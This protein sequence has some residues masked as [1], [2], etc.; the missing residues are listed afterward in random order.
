MRRT[1]SRMRWLLVL[2]AVCACSWGVAFADGPSPS[3]DGWI[4]LLGPEGTSLAAFKSPTGDWKAVPS[5]RLDPKNPKRL[6][7]VEKS[8]GDV[9]KGVV[10][11]NGPLGRT[12]NLVTK[13]VFGDAEIHLE[14][15]VPK[16]SNSGIK[17]QG[18]YEVQIFDSHGVAK[19][20]ASHNGGVYPR[21][22]LLP[23]YH[24]IDDGYPPKVNASKPP[25]EWQTLDIVWQSPK[26]DASG[27]KTANAK[28]V[29]VVLNG[30]VVQED[31]EVPCPTGHNWR[32]QE[33]PTGPIFL[34]ADHGP[35]AFRN[36]KIRPLA[37]P[38]EKA[39]DSRIGR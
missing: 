27:K 20:T 11:Y 32:N 18:V 38:S 9:K 12:T 37:K 8:A 19:A 23:T 4:D 26:F 39:K 17:T 1:H 3:G 6:V 15:L 29:K 34:Q 14:F 30:K 16:G 33:T 13:Q 31:L 21:A 5:V 24:H 22:E 36:V 10:W 7:A 25:G 2:A 28:F 35:V